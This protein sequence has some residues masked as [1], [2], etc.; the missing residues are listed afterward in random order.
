MKSINLLSVKSRGSSGSTKFSVALEGVN[1][2]FLLVEAAISR[3]EYNT[4]PAMEMRNLI[5]CITL[6]AISF[7]S[8]AQQKF[9][10]DKG[11]VTF[12]SN[13]EL[14]IIK[15]QSANVRGLLDPATNQFAFTV[16]IRTFRGF[17]SELQREHFLDNYME[18]EKFPKASFSGKIIE[19]I[20]FTKEGDYDVRAKG[21]LD[22]HGQKQTRI[23]KGKISVRKGVVVVESVFSVPLDEHSIVIPK[24]VNQKIATE[25]EVA[26]SATMSI[27]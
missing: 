6:L 24:I 22:I 5:F 20:D 8:G 18:I 19:Q 13:A 9:S 23:V 15:A 17:N 27:H 2:S 3:K 12:T 26:F 7:S 21:D 11:E 1:H 4:Q 14:E 10:T 25:I 16:D